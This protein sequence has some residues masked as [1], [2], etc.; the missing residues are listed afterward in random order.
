MLLCERSL[1]VNMLSFYYSLVF[2]LPFAY[3][4][5]LLIYALGNSSSIEIFD[6]FVVHNVVYTGAKVGQMTMWVH[7]F[8]RLYYVITNT[9]LYGR[10]LHEY[11][12]YTFFNNVAII[13]LFHKDDY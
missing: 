5:G 11:V 3:M 8:C 12:V 1:F 4:T 2:I 9:S 6:S 10:C 13:L 7:L